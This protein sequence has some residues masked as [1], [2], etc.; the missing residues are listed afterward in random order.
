MYLALADKYNNIV[1]N[2]NSNKVSLR[3]DTAYN[4]NDK[5]SLKYLPFLEGNYHFEAI[6]GVFNISD[7]SFSATPGYDFSNFLI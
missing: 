2:T 5:D 6:S 7:I 3:V 4:K 1:G